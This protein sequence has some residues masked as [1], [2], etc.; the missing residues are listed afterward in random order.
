[1]EIVTKIPVW[2]TSEAALSYLKNVDEIQRRFAKF[3]NNSKK[4]KTQIAKLLIYMFLDVLVMHV[5][6]STQRKS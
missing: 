1:M 4:K 2:Y 6:S 5:Y 3:L